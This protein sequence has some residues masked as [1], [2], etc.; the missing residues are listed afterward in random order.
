[1]DEQLLD[2]E[3]QPLPGDKTELL[4]RVERARAALEETIRPLSDAKLVAPGP[5]E[6]WSVKDHLAHLATWEQ[7]MAALLQQRPRYA[8][9]D[10][11]EKTYL[12][13]S[14]DDLNAIVYQHH[15]DRSPAE[16]LAAFRQAHRHLLA[17]L[18]GL[19]DADLFRT[20]SHYQP[21]EPGEDSGEPILKWIAGNTYEHY[22]EHQ[23]WIQA[24]V[25]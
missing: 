19:T 11:D 2:E 15:K 7:G 6:G 9:M 1:M 10:V 13:S 17:A 20:Y 4:E 23:A 18:D 25:A 22:A 8:A 21:D 16:V 5:Y 14:T 24:L 3:S 12:S